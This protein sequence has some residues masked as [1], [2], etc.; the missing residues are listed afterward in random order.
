MLERFEVVAIGIPFKSSSAPTPEAVVKMFPSKLMN[1]DT[2][3][4]T[5]VR[6]DTT[7]LLG[8]TTGAE[9]DKE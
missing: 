6:V 8:M 4:D 9:P 1:P 3:S 2:V 7:K 5:A